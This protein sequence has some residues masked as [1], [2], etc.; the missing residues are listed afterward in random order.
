MPRAGFANG[1]DVKDRGKKQIKDNSPR[2][3][4]LATNNIG[5]PSTDSEKTGKIKFGSGGSLFL[6]CLV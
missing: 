1:L 4:D 2:C 5:F 3:L 6:T